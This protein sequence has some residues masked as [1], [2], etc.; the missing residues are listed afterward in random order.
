[1][2]KLYVEHFDTNLCSALKLSHLFEM[3]IMTGADYL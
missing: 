3:S 2:G 1:M